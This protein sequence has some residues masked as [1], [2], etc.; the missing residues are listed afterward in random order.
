[1]VA[2][3]NNN[4]SWVRSAWS[5]VLISCLLER[6]EPDEP[7]PLECP[8]RLAFDDRG[9]LF[10]LIDPRWPDIA[11][12]TIALYPWAWVYFVLFIIITTFAVL[13]LFVGIIV[14]AMDII[15]DFEEEGKSVKE[16]IHKQTADLHNDIV[17]LR[18][19]ISQ[20]KDMIKK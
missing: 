20:M 13:N 19:E 7:D 2:C 4:H 14:D 8:A 18:Q 12:P 11:D 16:A 17:D 1:M 5:T 10:E 15:H 3:G 9:M 6:V